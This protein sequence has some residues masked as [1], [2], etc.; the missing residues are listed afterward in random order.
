MIELIKKGEVSYEGPVWDKISLEAKDL[1]RR[2]L[3]KNY[4][5]RYSPSQA[6]AHPWI[7]NVHQLFYFDHLTRLF[8]LDWPSFR[9]ENGNYDTKP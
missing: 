3:N 7:Q 9:Q 5:E 6:L 2:L 4:K 1:V 8:L